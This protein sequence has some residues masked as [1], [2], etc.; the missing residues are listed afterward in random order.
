MR[1]AWCAAK[2]S[3]ENDHASFG[4][5]PASQRALV[6][7]RLHPVQHRASQHAEDPPAAGRAQQSDRADLGGQRGVPRRD[8]SADRPS[9]ALSAGRASVILPADR[10]AACA[11]PVLRRVP[12]QPVRL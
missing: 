10:G 2:P 1:A 4:F 11:V 6:R 12:L 5:R 3:T 9:L 8:Q 7:R